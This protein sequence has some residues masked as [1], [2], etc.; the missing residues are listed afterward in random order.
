MGAA[1]AAA[2]QPGR[3]D[4]RVHLLPILD[5]ARAVGDG[6][7]F[8]VVHKRVSYGDELPHLSR[9]RL[10]QRLL[11]ARDPGGRNLVVESHRFAVGR[12]ELRLKDP[13]ELLRRAD[14]ELEVV[15]GA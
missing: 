7:H 11:T 8:A 14:D 13:L 10:W 9:D 3:F 2:S 6:V 4:S 15:L 12:S 1:W 5:E